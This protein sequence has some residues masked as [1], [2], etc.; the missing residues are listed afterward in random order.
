M[1]V[2]EWNK[3]LDEEIQF[4]NDLKSAAEKLRDNYSGLSSLGEI[5]IN[6][7]ID[8]LDDSQKSFNDLRDAEEHQIKKLLTKENNG[9]ERAKDQIRKV[10]NPGAFGRVLLNKW[11]STY[12]SIIDLN[13]AIAANLGI[14]IFN[15]DFEYDDEDLEAESG[16]AD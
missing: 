12:Q 8:E 3:A 4:L 13:H 6:A 5:L 2:P 10:K 14:S 11:V 15:Y 1:P 9:L 7:S 16:K